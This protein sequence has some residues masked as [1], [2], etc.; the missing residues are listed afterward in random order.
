VRIFTNLAQDLGRL[1]ARG[2]WKIWYILIAATLIQVAF[3]YLATPGPGLIGFEPRDLKT[4]IASVGWSV[5]LLWFVPRTLTGPLGLTRRHLGLAFGDF[6]GGLLIVFIGGALA[7]LLTGLASTDT[8][9]QATYPWPGSWVG[10]SLSTLLTWAGLYILYYA[11]FEFFYRGFLLRALEKTLGLLPAI[12]IQAFAAT[13]VHFGK[14]FTETVSAFP[15][16]LIFALIA[17]RTK[18]LFY[19]VA[20]H[21][22]VGISTDIFSLARQGQLFP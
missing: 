15:A 17:V 12:W 1:F 4:A 3:W 5:L 19:P 22:I 8:A 7:V 16:S 20:L 9:L 14:P 18:S 6:R 21:F 10:N 11:S 13:M 2:A